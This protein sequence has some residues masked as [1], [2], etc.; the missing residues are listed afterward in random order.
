MAAL[1][2]I[3]KTYKRHK[4]EHTDSSLSERAIRLA[5]KKGGAALYRSWKSRVDMR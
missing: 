4:E 3:A 2:S 1:Y 5:I